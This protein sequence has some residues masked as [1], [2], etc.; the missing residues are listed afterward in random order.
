MPNAAFWHR[1]RLALRRAGIDVSRFPTPGSAPVRRSKQLV[2]HG[3]EIVLDV[4]A[5]TGAYGLELRRH[6]FGGRILSVE[7]L[8]S[9]FAVLRRVAA[10]DAEWDAVNTALGES[11]GRAVLNV[12]GNADSSSFLPML[13]AHERAA[14]ASCYSGT[15]VVDV[16]T[17]AELLEARLPTAAPLFVKLDVQGFERQVL[18]GAPLARITGLELELSLVPL[19]EDSMLFPE[20]LSLLADHGFELCSVD[21]GFSDPDTGRLLQMDGVFFRSGGDPRHDTPEA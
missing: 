16:V 8:A 1:G 4:G 18:A 13:P 12:A 10:R 5:A 14:P 11:T 6:G 19:Y 7:P 20:A 21:A 9:S 17:M 2:S 15:E 3:V